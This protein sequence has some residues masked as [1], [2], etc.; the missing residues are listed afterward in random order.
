MDAQIYTQVSKPLL[1]WNCNSEVFIVISRIILC[2]ECVRLFGIQ[3]WNCIVSARISTS[4]FSCS[5]S[6]FAM[7]A[8]ANTFV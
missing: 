2:I 7:C 4:P 5:S 1:E 3:R 6:Y 8:I